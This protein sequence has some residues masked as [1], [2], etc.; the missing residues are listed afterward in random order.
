MEQ[1][2]SHYI[3][4]FGSELPPAGLHQRILEIVEP[5]LLSAALT[6]TL[7]NQFKAAE[8]LGINRNTLRKKISTYNLQVVK[9]SKN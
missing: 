9:I 4:S 6:A 5:P 2:L 8:L 3:A 7:G 1:Y